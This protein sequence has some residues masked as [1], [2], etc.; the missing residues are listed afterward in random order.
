[1]DASTMPSAISRKAITVGLSFS[2]ARAGWTVPLA[3]WRAR[4]VAISTNRKRL[5]TLSRQSSTVTRA[6]KPPDQSDVKMIAKREYTCSRAPFGMARLF[7]QQGPER[8]LELVVDD[9]II[10]LVVVRHLR[11][12]LLHAARDHLL[13]VL[14]AAAQALLQGLARGR[15]HEDAGGL[16]E[17][18]AHLARALPIDLEHHVGA[19][20]ELVLQTVLGGPIKIAEHLGVLEKGPRRHHGLERL[21]RH[22]VI[23][24]PVA[25]AR[26]HRPRGV[27]DRQGKVG[28]E[29]EQLAHQTRLARA[30]GRGDHVK[31]TLIHANCVGRAQKRIS[32]P[33]SRRPFVPFVTRYDPLLPED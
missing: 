25:L 13:A 32:T 24:D 12:G 8:A 18:G 9:E 3:N 20:V 19:T 2:Q 6:I 10:V 14:T 7:A 16:G 22:K 30:R 29:L 28:R 5:S 4:R 31:Q 23:I 11:R 27:R 1:M 17:G 26:S 33:N 21:D 15:Q